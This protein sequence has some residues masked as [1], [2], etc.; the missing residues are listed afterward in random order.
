M[1]K[2]FAQ[3]LHDTKKARSKA[4]GREYNEFTWEEIA[5]QIGEPSA[6]I[7]R[8]KKLEGNH[9]PTT[10]AQWIRLEKFFGPEVWNF[11]TVDPRTGKTD[12]ELADFMKHRN[13]PEIR[14]QMNDI[15]GRQRNPDKYANQYVTR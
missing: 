2:S 11:A 12:T 5:D 8:W 3:F 4:A 7:Y 15:L 14:A 6:N 10:L 13:Q 1:S 9:L